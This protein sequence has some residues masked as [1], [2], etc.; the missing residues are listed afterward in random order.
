[1]VS[2]IK[3][4]FIYLKLKY[5]FN[6]KKSLLKSI[7]VDKSI[8]VEN[9]VQIPKRVYI[10]ENVCIGKCT[11]LSSNTII[12]S[13]VK[14]GKFCSFGPNIHIAPG[15]HYLNFV[16]THPILFNQFWRNKIGIKEKSNYVNGLKDLSK[17]TIIGNDVWIG[18]NVIVCRGVKIGNG[19]VVG[20]GAVVTNDVP[21]YSVVVG[22]PA[23][24]IKYRFNDD[25][26]QFLKEYQ[27]WNRENID[28]DTMYNIEELMKENEN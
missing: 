10:R 7:N 28:I 25:E 15:N 14:I 20:A 5:I 8:S 21:D 2:L 22:V 19:A 26:I 3:K 23:K 1:M 16:S 17:E 13:N 12:E 27:W 18:A 24:V 11:Y 4:I 6:K 9:Y